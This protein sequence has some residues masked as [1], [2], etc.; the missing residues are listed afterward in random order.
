MLSIQLQQMFFPDIFQKECFVAKVS[1]FMFNWSC[2]IKV[3]LD[4]AG[5]CSRHNSKVSDPSHVKV[6]L[7]LFSP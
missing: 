5:F 4:C 7:S 2:L 1:L 3:M 6:S